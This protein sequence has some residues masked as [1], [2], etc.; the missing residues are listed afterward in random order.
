MAEKQQT[1]ILLTPGFAKDESDDFIP[2]LQLFV[3]NLKK[4]YPDLHIIILAFQYPYCTGDYMLHGARVISFNGWNKRKAYRLLVWAKVWFTLTRLVREYQVLGLLSFWFGDCAFIGTFFGRRHR[5]KHFSWFM[6]QD[7]RAGNKFFSW[8]R[9]RADNLIVLSDALAG[10]IYRNYALK[11]RHR[12]P[13]GVDPAIFPGE[14][15]LRNI[16]IL[17]AG[18]LIPLKRYDLFLDVIQQLVAAFPNLKV[19]LCGQGPEKDAL[20]RRIEKAQLQDHVTLM[21]E[22]PHA[23]VLALMQQS[24]IFMHTSAYEGFAAVCAEALYAGAQVVSFCQP[25]HQP[26]P[27]WHIVHSEKALVNQLALLLGDK[28]LPH[29]R[30]LPFTMAGACANIMALFGYQGKDKGA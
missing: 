18:S 24:K 28:N 14:P 5:L 26:I 16:D 4:L 25:I 23:Q 21:D 10:E 1:L 19:V 8:I 6:G 12:I 17:G 13:F 22:V 7:A 15:G 2:V 20:V 29:E 9:P 11:P 30:V 3:K 27:Q